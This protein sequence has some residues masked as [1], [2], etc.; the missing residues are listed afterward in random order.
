MNAIDSV[1]E[2]VESI[3]TT[4]A[5]DRWLDK[6]NTEIASL[7]KSKAKFAI[8]KHPSLAKFKYRCYTYNDWVIVFRITDT[9]FEVCRFIWGAR[10]A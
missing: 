5:G 7:A 10:L 4:G 2:Y 3:N 6:L 1:A 9:T 8:C